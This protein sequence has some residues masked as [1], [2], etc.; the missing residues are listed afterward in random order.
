[1]KSGVFRHQGWM[2]VWLRPR[3]SCCNSHEWAVVFGNVKK[4]KPDPAN[5]YRAVLISG[6]A[7]E[8]YQ[9]A[10]L[11]TEGTSL[12]SESYLR[13]CCHLDNPLQHQSGRS[14]TDRLT[15]KHVCADKLYSREIGVVT[16]HLN[17]LRLPWHHPALP[18]GTL[19]HARSDWSLLSASLWQRC[20][21]ITLS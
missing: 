8:E 18:L 12:H 10:A 19:F 7:L 16:P 3:E 14:Q 6:P 5:M 9:T 4:K 11:I 17:H 1:M 2:E 15:H 21:L 20:E 13:L